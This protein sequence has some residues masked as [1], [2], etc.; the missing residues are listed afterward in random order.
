MLM[1]AAL[2]ADDL[3]PIT[4]RGARVLRGVLLED[5]LVVVNK[6]TRGRE[7][8]QAL[9]EQQEFDEPRPGIAGTRAE[10]PLVIDRGTVRAQVD[11]RREGRSGYR[12]LEQ[13][14]TL[15]GETPLP[16]ISLVERRMDV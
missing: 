10:L 8:C 1:G 4:E 12:G 15:G 13:G 3:R 5:P 6:Q 7:V 11:Q 2:G 9:L 14:M 16:P